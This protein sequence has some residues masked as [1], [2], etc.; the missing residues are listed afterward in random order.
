MKSIPC[1]PI[2][3]PHHLFPIFQKIL[4]RFTR[5]EIPK[6][7]K[8]YKSQ[9]KSE[10]QGLFDRH[11]PKSNFNVQHKATHIANLIDFFR[12]ALCP[13]CSNASRSE[14]IE[15]DRDLWCVA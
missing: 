15:I 3:A 9:I 5:H 13:E 1:V 4:S 10:N 12:S 8:A 2:H 7:K 6:Y 14:I 11:T